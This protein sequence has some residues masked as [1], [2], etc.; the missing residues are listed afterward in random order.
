MRK[1]YRVMSKLRTSKEVLKCCTSWYANLF[2]KFP[3]DINREMKWWSNKSIIIVILF[4][5]VLLLLIGYFYFEYNKEEGFQ[6]ASGT[7]SGR[8]SGTPNLCLTGTSEEKCNIDCVKDPLPAPTAD[9]EQSYLIYE[10]K[11]LINT[12]ESKN[13]IDSDLTLPPIVPPTSTE[14]YNS[15]GALSPFDIDS[16]KEIPWD[17][18]NKDIDP[19]NCLFGDVCAEASQLIFAK[20]EMQTLFGDIY[21]IGYDDDNSVFKYKSQLFG[22]T[23]FDENEAAALQFG[24][25]FINLK[26]GEL[27]S[28]IF[29]RPFDAAENYVTRKYEA[30]IKLRD[31]ISD[32]KEALSKNGGNKSLAVNEV[33]KNY[34]NGRYDK[35]WHDEQEKYT[36]TPLS[37]LDKTPGVDD[38]KRGPVLFGRNSINKSPLDLDFS[39]PNPAVKNKK[40]LAAIE[41]IIN[42]KVD[43]YAEIQKASETINNT[44]N[45]KTI[46]SLQFKTITNI[47]RLIYKAN[48]SYKN[49]SISKGDRTVGYSDL[50]FLDGNKRLNAKAA[51]AIERSNK[52][53]A[54]LI[55][56]RAVELAM[57]LATAAITSI[58]LI[59]VASSG[60][61]AAA[62][63]AVLAPFVVSS[64]T[65]LVIGLAIQLACATFVPAIFNSIIE[66]DAVCPLNDDGTYMFNFDDCFYGR[67]EYSTCDYP[68]SLG[69]NVAGHF[70]YSVLQ[71]LPY[72]FGDLLS[73]FGPYI[74]FSKN[75]KDWDITKP[76]ESKKPIRLK[77]NLRT[78]PYYY[79]PTLSLYNSG[80]KPKFQAGKSNLDQRLFNPLTFHY[81]KDISIP[82]DKN[83]QVGY[84]VW[85]DFAN[86]IMLNKMAQ[87][88]YDASRK[89]YTTT[90]DGMLAFQY[91]SK[92]YGLISTTELTCDVQCEIT[93]IKFN[94][95]TGAK[96]CEVIIPN[97]DDNLGAKY[98]DRRFYFFKDMRRGVVN[99]T[100]QIQ[101]TN[102]I[103]LE[104]LMEDNLNIYTVTA[105]TNTNGTAPDC[106]TYNSEGNSV[107]NP[108]ISLGPPS[109]VYNG[110]LVD[111]TAKLNSENKIPLESRCGQ[112]INF[113]RYNGITH[114]AS[115]RASNTN[116]PDIKIITNPQE[117]NWIYAYKYSLQ[118]K[119]NRD[120]NDEQ[121]YFYPSKNVENDVS[122]KAGIEVT[123]ASDTLRTTK[124]MSIIWNTTCKYDDTDCQ[125][126]TKTGIGTIVQ[127]TLEGLV[128]L[129]FGS[130][131]V[132]QAYSRNQMQTRTSTLSSRTN[133]G[134]QAA[135]YAGPL[136]QAAIGIQFP[137]QEASISQRISCLY[138]ELVNAEDTYIL[139]GRVMTS[140]QGFII[141]HGPFINWAPGYVPTIQACNKQS[142]ELFDC[143]NSYALRRFVNKY[144]T[145]YPGQQIKK[146]NN[147]IPTLNTGTKWNVNTSKAMCIYDIDI[148]LF[149]NTNFKEIPNTT[150]TK[151]IGVV[152]KQN[153]ANKTCTFEPDEIK[154]NSS[155]L[156]PPQIFSKNVEEPLLPSEI[157][158]VTTALLDPS[159]AA[160]EGTVVTSAVNTS[161]PLPF[162]VTSDRNSG[163]YTRDVFRALRSIRE[164]DTIQAIDAIASIKNVNVKTL[165]P[166][167]APVKDTINASP[168][169]AKFDCSSPITQAKLIEK[170][171]SAHQDIPILKSV[172]NA[173]SL[174]TI[175]KKPYCFF[176]GQFEIIDD[177][178]INRLNR[179]AE[180]SAEGSPSGKPRKIVKPSG[181]SALLTRKI[182]IFL[183]N[184][185]EFL[186][187]DFPIFYTHVQIPK[188]SQW[189]D[190]PPRT[191]VNVPG[192]LTRPG[193]SSDSLYN[194]YNDCS[195]SALINTIVEEYNTKKTD[196]KILKVL[197][198][199]TP[200]TN[201]PTCDYDVEILKNVGDKTIINRETVR[202]ALTT[203]QTIENCAYNLDLVETNR[204][205]SK[206]N[207]GAT[208]NLSDTVGILQTPYTTAIA[209][210]KNTKEDTISAIRN[211]LG[212]N[213]ADAVKSTTIDILR[214]FQGVRESLYKEA[215]L[216]NCPSKTCMDD[217]II[218]AMVNR[219]NY[220]NYPAYP[221]N[222]NTVTKN[223]II[224]V[225]KVGTST[226]RECQVELYL[227]TD[228][229]VDFLYNPLTQDTKYYMHNY[230]F[231]LIETS[232]PCTFKVKPFTEID[233]KENRMDISGDAF[234]L[235]CPPAPE[236]CPSIITNS[237]SA[238]YSWVKEDYK[239]VMI[240]C[241]I[242][243]ENDPVLQTVK[244]IYD[245]IAII[246]KSNT[247]YFNSILR[248]TKVFNAK[249]NILEFKI[250]AKRVHW[251][252]DYNIIYYTGDTSDNVEDS[253]LKVV[254]PEGTSYE[255]E[256]G[257]Y[258]KDS[259]GI[260]VEAPSLIEGF[261]A[262]ID[263][264]KYYAAKDSTGVMIKAPITYVNGMTKCGSL[265]MA[266]PTIEEIFYPDLTFTNTE[267]FR[268][269]SGV[270]T[271]VFLPYLANDGLTPVD[272][273]QTR[274]YT[275]NPVNCSI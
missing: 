228:F 249:P 240:R 129:G 274:K 15:G 13:Y 90:D 151:K 38:L 54:K 218:K 146:I 98:H 26:L 125:M 130:S 254:W 80:S 226:P 16:K 115:S 64:T 56:R 244:N 30:Q 10:S 258:W 19:A 253:Y 78:P 211:F 25:V 101:Q 118:N 82:K 142:I 165:A 214:K 191:F 111:I 149:D 212:Y 144:H 213:I 159:S 137:G 74:C 179:E 86:P 172:S 124:Y 3:T 256:T 88:Y 84:P 236:E 71:S 183:D 57:G 4:I 107:P 187:D 209:H 164:N 52:L 89:C 188:M 32:Y 262:L 17:Y 61:F 85:V 241:D 59:A 100:T 217:T 121:K 53:T 49:T 245:K 76:P 186:F 227:R 143:V 148:V 62:T 190:V 234:A 161:A 43:I 275:C 42:S 158:S 205:L 37:E 66:Y 170:F 2:Y 185:G 45:K 105:C 77:N 252:N 138:D 69:G 122:N 201:S 112:N 75:D 232:R 221:P 65:V 128:G 140:R 117:D 132:Q 246:T 208:L 167:I 119:D 23:V 150:E 177:K 195:N 189:F 9:E 259:A 194:D 1:V 27:M 238:S 91:I 60:P 176:T 8:A 255:V 133:A 200:K 108:V 114:P 215:S 97:P 155:E 152:Q 168:S 22:F 46:P 273:R 55:T 270:Q 193:C 202:L 6:T 67:K 5:G 58:Y 147:I 204:N 184:N 103:A 18:D 72:G 36:G 243:N 266:T 81:N 166:T 198:A 153:V 106:I 257:Y 110:P 79:D 102:T 34:E 11:N 260:F 207:S 192:A 145:K 44:A 229:F 87:F 210:S 99:R 136:V 251:D 261:S 263:T 171:N 12:Y 160:G 40:V 203:Q 50:N 174:S 126:G 29:D 181:G 268:T 223:T 163:V 239:E 116:D 175:G 104:A 233:I 135:T 178:L 24:E 123:K 173:T 14:M 47:N 222:Q 197:R 206:S 131:L 96:I 180:L 63:A 271:K 113:S 264:T 250:S 269:I 39:D 51:A 33:I 220:D 224:R 28:N 92:F 169:A 230:A 272:T 35:L 247:N 95:L 265:T 157:S 196:S 93:E 139:N 156:F 199:F 21:N 83:G 134:L 216:F 127:G 73:A 120:D 20:C 41:K 242:T 225:T 235:N 267:I 109:G 248:V 162:S 219:Y 48:N 141:D 231:K 31:Q 182:R 154:D 94:P 237:S 68:A 70:I 7:A